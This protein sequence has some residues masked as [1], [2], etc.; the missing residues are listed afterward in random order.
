MGQELPVEHYIE[1]IREYHDAIRQY[2]KAD[3]VFADG[4]KAQGDVFITYVEENTMC[5][6]ILFSDNKTNAK[7]QILICAAKYDPFRR[8]YQLLENMTAA[9]IELIEDV[10]A[11]NA[12]SGIIVRK[13]R[14]ILDKSRKI[15][16]VS[17]R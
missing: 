12:T 13:Q 3:I 4:T 9:E 15:E 17:F 2:T 16:S 14:A 8:G 5:M 1:K 6:Y 11:Q 7:G 10:I